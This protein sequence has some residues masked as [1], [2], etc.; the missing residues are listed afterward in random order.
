MR[1]AE[2]VGIGGSHG[3]SLQQSCKTSE[4]QIDW[5]IPAFEPN[6]DGILGPV[7]YDIPY[8]LSRTPDIE[9]LVTELGER[10]AKGLVLGAH[11]VRSEAN[12]WKANGFFSN[13]QV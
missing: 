5:G 7:S 6:Y 2:V 12:F 8:I 13:G 10:A 4:K 1:G 11:D 3:G 9:L